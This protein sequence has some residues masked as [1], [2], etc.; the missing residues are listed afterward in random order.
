MLTRAEA[1]TCGRASSRF[2]TARAILTFPILVGIT[3]SPLDGQ[4]RRK[5]AKEC[6]EFPAFHEMDLAGIEAVMD[7]ILED[8]KNENAADALAR[9][10]TLLPEP[11]VEQSIA[12]AVRVAILDPKGV[13]LATAE[14]VAK[15][16][17]VS[18][19]KVDLL[20]DV[21]RAVSRC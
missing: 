6:A 19:A 4:S 15:T 14:K 3:G 10:I 5:L 8:L 13:K 17:G 18:K 21:G 12:L 20:A 9:A 1:R 16:M 7:G 2:E 11:L